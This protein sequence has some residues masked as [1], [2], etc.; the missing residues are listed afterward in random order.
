MFFITQHD[1]S[2]AIQ[3]IQRLLTTFQLYQQQSI[4]KNKRKTK[5]LFIYFFLFSF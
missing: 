3:I 2:L 4:G 5:N 1:S